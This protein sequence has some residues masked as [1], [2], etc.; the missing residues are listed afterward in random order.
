[1]M[2]TM[3]PGSLKNSTD[4]INEITFE[5][6]ASEIER[7][8]EILNFNNDLWALCQKSNFINEYPLFI[9]IDVCGKSDY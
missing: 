3:T 5:I 2:T 1:M 7:G 6:I 4:R 8:S 9:E